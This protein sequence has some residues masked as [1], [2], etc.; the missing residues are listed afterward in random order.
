MLKNKLQLIECLEYSVELCDKNIFRLEQALNSDY[1]SWLPKSDR[2]LLR[3]E[4]NKEKTMKEK[5]KESLEFVRQF[6][7][8]DY[9]EKHVRTT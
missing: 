7:I 3:E 2:N 1:S 6:N 5:I 8:E 9:G 4:I